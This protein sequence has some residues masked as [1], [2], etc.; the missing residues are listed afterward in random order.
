MLI[1][2][3]LFSKMMRKYV[4]RMELGLF[5]AFAFL[6]LNNFPQVNDTCEDTAGTGNIDEGK[7][8]I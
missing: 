7:Y 6:S 4:R 8:L 3:I 1:S 5:I 2:K